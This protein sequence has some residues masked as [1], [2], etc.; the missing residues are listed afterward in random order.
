MITA[1]DIKK[2]EKGHYV[3]MLNG[4]MIFAICF[5]IIVAGWALRFLVAFQYMVV[6]GSVTAWYFAR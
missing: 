5:N 6:A 3:Y 2:D 4:A 1:G